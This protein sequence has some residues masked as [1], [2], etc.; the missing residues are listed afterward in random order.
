MEFVC[1]SPAPAT[2]TE[3][4]D[5]RELVDT[6]AERLCRTGREMFEMGVTQRH[7]FLDGD[8]RLFQ[9]AYLLPEDCRRF[10]W[11]GQWRSGPAMRPTRR[12]HGQACWRADPAA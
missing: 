12:R 11:D 6:E 7:S 8:G 5:L 3:A 4:G 1:V 10:P 9:R 2:R